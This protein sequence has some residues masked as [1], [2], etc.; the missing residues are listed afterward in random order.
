MIKV[1]TAGVG[2][3]KFFDVGVS[4]VWEVKLESQSFLSYESFSLWSE[5]SKMNS[6][7]QQK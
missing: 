4:I 3:K 6:F 5:Q 2:S 7:Y 1:F